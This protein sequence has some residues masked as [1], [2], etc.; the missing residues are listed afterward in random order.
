[1]GA[2]LSVLLGVGI[3][4]IVGAEILRRRRKRARAAV[5]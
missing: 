3:A 2:L 1:M 4:A 5:G